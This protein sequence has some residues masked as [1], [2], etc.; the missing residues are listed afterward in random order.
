M[1]SPRYEAKTL[2]EVLER[3]DQIR[4]DNRDYYVQLRDLRFEVANRPSD[5]KQRP[6]TQAFA[7]FRV[8]LPE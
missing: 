7:A 3:V 1:V 5:G 4:R 8:T 2:T 6:A